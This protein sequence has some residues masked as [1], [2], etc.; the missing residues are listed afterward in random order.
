MSRG[1]G[2]VYKRQVYVG[3]QDTS[4]G[5]P[6]FLNEQKLTA[7]EKTVISG[8]YTQKQ[9]VNDDISIIVYMGS[10]QGTLEPH[11]ISVSSISI[12]KKD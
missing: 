7:N 1:L 5:S 4:V 2:D 10:A 11:T 3:I 9:T 6:Y 8:V 12:E